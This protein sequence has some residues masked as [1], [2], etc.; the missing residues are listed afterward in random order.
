MKKILLLGIYLSI[1]TVICSAVNDNTLKTLCSVGQYKIGT[2]PQLKVGINRIVNDTEQHAQAYKSLVAIADRSRLSREV[3][4]KLSYDDYKIFEENLDFN[5]KLANEALACAIVG[6]AQ[7]NTKYIARTL[8]ILKSFRQNVIPGTNYVFYDSVK[9]NEKLAKKIII[10]LAKTYDLSYSFSSASEKDANYNWLV[11]MVQHILDE[12]RWNVWRDTPESVW[13]NTAL[14]TVAVATR[15]QNIVN[16]ADNRA[17]RQ[18]REFC[19]EDG[20]WKNLE[21]TAAVEVSEALAILADVTLN[22]IT[23]NLYYFKNSRNVNYLYTMLKAPISYMTG[24]GVIPGARGVPSKTLSG[25]AYMLGYK[26]YRDIM[27]AQTAFLDTNISPVN[28]LFNYIKPDLK[29]NSNNKQGTIVNDKIG[30]GILRSNPD[31]QTAFYIRLQYGKYNSVLPATDYLSV[32]FAT[33]T[34]PISY[35]KSWQKN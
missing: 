8:D 26:A 20:S 12:T 29:L 19:S 21:W 2:I 16:L 4:K 30:W 14:G 15:R 31:P 24:Y 1:C 23:N 3:A 22:H 33:P 35:Y 18:L 10:T 5:E 7:A 17:K 11:N 28:L 32:F 9:L 6:I 25:S 34:A 27:F 13:A